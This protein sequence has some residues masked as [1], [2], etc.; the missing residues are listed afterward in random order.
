LLSIVLSNLALFRVFLSCFCNG[1]VN[2][3][4]GNKNTDEEEE[5]DENPQSKANG[6]RTK[7]AYNDSGEDEEEGAV[8]NSRDSA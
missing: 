5:E 4:G 3:I 1:P 8:S 7:D 2:E 6:S